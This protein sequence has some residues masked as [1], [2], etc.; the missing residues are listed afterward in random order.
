MQDACGDCLRQIQCEITGA[1]CPKLD[2]LIHKFDTNGRTTMT[3]PGKNSATPKPV[4]EAADK[5]INTEEPTVP[6]QQAA[7]PNIETNTDRVVDHNRNTIFAG[8]SDEIVA[9]LNENA[10]MI[11]VIQPVDGPDLITS[12]DYLKKHQPKLSVVQRAKAAAEKL[13]KNHKAMLI[14]GASVVAV[15]LAVKN[16][17]KD[18]KVEVLDDEDNTINGIGDEAPDSV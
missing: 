15:G 18:M 14:L 16:S 10:P 9:W 8:T 3:N 13:G 5:T 12:V 2:A 1:S 7:S 17:R 11:Y 4:V 6:A